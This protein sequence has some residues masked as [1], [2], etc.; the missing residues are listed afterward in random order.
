MLVFKQLYTF[1]KVS[2]SIVTQG[3][4][5]GIYYNSTLFYFYNILLTEFLYFLCYYCVALLVFGSGVSTLWG[6]GPLFYTYQLS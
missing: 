4:Y 6:A 2:C 5:N 3:L 1:F